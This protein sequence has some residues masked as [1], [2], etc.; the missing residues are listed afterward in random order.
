MVQIIAEVIRSTQYTSIG[1]LISTCISIKG[2]KNIFPLS[3]SKVKIYF[4]KYLI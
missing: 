2:L 1:L 4:Y 3:I